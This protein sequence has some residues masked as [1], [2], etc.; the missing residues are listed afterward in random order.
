VPAY[1]P[2]AEANRRLRRYEVALQN[3]E[4]GVAAAPRDGSLRLKRAEIYAEVG[5]WKEALACAEEVLAL[6]PGQPD[7]AALRE[8]ARRKLG[9]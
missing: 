7:A 2:L 3:L 1:L 5:M 9:R 8:E 6:L 4:I